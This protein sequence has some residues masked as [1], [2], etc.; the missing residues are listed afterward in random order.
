M[1]DV[2]V[3]KPLFQE[4]NLNLKIKKLKLSTEALLTSYAFFALCA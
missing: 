3:V 1:I 4:F 2:E